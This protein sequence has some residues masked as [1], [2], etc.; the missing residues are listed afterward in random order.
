MA[1]RCLLMLSTVFLL[2]LASSCEDS[3]DNLATNVIGSQFVVGADSLY[4]QME[5]QAA[6]SMYYANDT[7]MLGE[8]FD[9]YYGTVKAEVLIEVLPNDTLPTIRKTNAGQW[10]NPTYQGLALV[11]NHTVLNGSVNSPLQISVYQKNDTLDT[12]KQ[13]Y[14]NVD[15]QKYCQQDIFLADKWVTG[16]SY[17]RITSDKLRDLGQDLFDRGRNFPADFKDSKKFREEIFKGLYLTTSNGPGLM[18]NLL[19]IDNNDRGYYLDLRLIY[20]FNKFVFNDGTEKNDTIRRDSLFFT[21][22]TSSPKAQKIINTVNSARLTESKF[23]YVS[24]PAGL[25]PKI[26]MDLPRIQQKFEN[27][28][29]EKGSNANINLNK[30]VLTLKLEENEDTTLPMP[31]HLMLI[32]KDS[33]KVFF[34]KGRFYDGKSSFL[35]TRRGNQYLF[36][37]ARY[38]QQKNSDGQMSEQDTMIV[39]PVGYSDRYSHFREKI[40]L[41]ALRFHSDSIQIDFI[42]NQLTTIE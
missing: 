41:S 11:L 18:L 6:D 7:L 34:E 31:T 12:K 20:Q 36:D 32:Q 35:G 33:L 29:A 22:F 28:E 39:V 19:A 21:A 3:L 9:K 24:S 16:E 17:I 13:Y 38:I 14:T 8:F 40:G 4:F 25:Q 30:A 23:G 15:I 37:I 26:Y 42:Y 10:E 27:F 1:K 2:V 5:Q